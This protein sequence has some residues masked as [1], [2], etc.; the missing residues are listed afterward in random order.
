MTTYQVKYLMGDRWFS[1][2]ED[3][4]L[5]VARVRLARC[6]ESMSQAARSHIKQFRILERTVTERVVE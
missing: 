1:W 3:G 4:D 6:K 2:S 5:E